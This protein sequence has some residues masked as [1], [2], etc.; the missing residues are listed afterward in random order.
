MIAKHIL[1]REI[2]SAEERDEPS[3][4]AVVEL[5]IPVARQ[6]LRDIDTM[7]QK[8]EKAARELSRAS[9]DSYNKLFEIDLE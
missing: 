8:L 7:D 4:P 5:P 1:E 2:K 3:D 9:E 6:L